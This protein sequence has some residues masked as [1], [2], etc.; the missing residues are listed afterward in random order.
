MANKNYI[1][2]D[3]RMEDAAWENAKTY[4]GFRKLKKSGGELAEE[5]TIMKILPAE[6]RVYFGFQCMEPNMQQVIESTPDRSMWGS[7]RI[8]LFLSPT[9]DTF[10]YYQ[11]VVNF[12]GKMVSHYYAEGGKIRP[13]PYAPQWS[14]KVFVGEDYWSLVMEIPL[15]ALYMTTNDNMRDK[16]LVGAI[17]NRTYDKNAPLGIES[18]CCELEIDYTEL[19]KYLVVD[20]MPQRSLENDIRIVM[21][22]ADIKGTD[23]D[24]YFGELCIKTMNAVDETFT[25]ASNYGEA[26]TV[27]LVAGSNEF[28]APCRFPKLGQYSVELSLTRTGDGEVFARKYPVKVDYEPIKLSFTLP[29]Y[30]CNFYPGQDYTKVVGRVVAAKPVTLKLEGP[31]IETQVKSPNADGS[32][33]FDTHGFEVGEAWLTATIDGEEKKQKIRRLAPTERMMTW[34]S[35]GNLIVNG[36]PE[37]MRYMYAPNYRGSK[38]LYA[39]RERENFHET[40]HIKCQDGWMKPEVVLGQLGLSMGEVFQDVMPSEP[41]L[42]Y[43]DRRIEELKNTDFAYYYLFDEPE[44]TGISP[45]YVKNCYDYVA[46]KD[47]YHVVMTTSRDVVTFGAC[48]D[49]FQVHPYLKPENL[50]DGRRVYWHTMNSIGS[51]I[52]DILKMNRSDKCVG[53]LPTAF[54]YEFK[55]RYADYPTFDEII[56]HTWAAVLRGAKSLNPYA[57]HD[58]NDRPSVLE[59]MRYIFATFE[60][61]EKFILLGK[62]T[63][64]LKNREA[65]AVL[66]DLGDEKMFALAN[67]NQTPQTV[68]LEGISGTWHDFRHNRTITGNTFEMQPFEVVVGTT[69]VKDEGLPTYEEV[70]ALIDEQEYAR[71][72]GGSLLF[73]RQNDIEVLEAKGVSAT[74]YKLF[75]GM[76]EDLAMQVSHKG[77]RFY[78][79]DVSKVQA[80]MEKVVITGWNLASKVALKLFVG[81]QEVADSVAEVKTEELSV[82]FLLKRPVCP[83]ALRLEFT[84]DEEMEVY[85]IDAF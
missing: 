64:L 84:G 30:R 68:T 28:T 32:F 36:K 62:Q 9:G 40:T 25:F 51:Y 3:G 45:I 79:L 65:E 33:E 15:K 72:H 17:R 24:G 59:G 44:C 23:T 38:L 22:T 66:Y 55:S 20:G 83:D 26:V 58:M 13:D 46:D 80:T 14:S 49:W 85:E 5:Q 67:F 57:L 74:K 34:I 61:L 7:D 19:E 6:D 60:A 78:T 77:D 11:F 70:A 41:M 53:F 82:T 10:S 18:S 21:A 50:D 29:E 56:C 2:L 8:E 35:G 37:M 69:K 43:F 52:D 54:S 47:P 73:A 48:A 1:T 75:N 81:G 71:T 12:A 42:R 39:Q 31:G 16:W 27:N 63:V 4:T 76:R